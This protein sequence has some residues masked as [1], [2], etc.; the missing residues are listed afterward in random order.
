M[1]DEV[2][3]NKAGKNPEAAFFTRLEQF[4]FA[5]EDAFDFRGDRQRS[6]NGRTG[7]LA[8]SK[9]RAEKG[10]APTSELG[11]TYGPI[12]KF[13]LDWIFVRPVGLT[14]PHSGRQSY[15]FAPHFGRTLKELNQSIPDRISDHDP[16]TV[17]LPLSEPRSDN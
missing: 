5:D 14:D 16:I 13:K 12:G 3:T 9:E 11:R 2:E 17:D 7:K 1:I 15:R 4:R 6:S 10:F 8:N